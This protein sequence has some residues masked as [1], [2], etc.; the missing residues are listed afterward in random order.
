MCGGD[1]SGRGLTLGTTDAL[2][3]GV[4]LR[5]TRR[6]WPGTS[7][8]AR[9]AGGCDL[10]GAWPARRGLITVLSSCRPPR[11]P[12]ALDAIRRTRMTRSATSSAT[13]NDMPRT[14]RL[15]AGWVSGQVIGGVDT[16]GRTHHAAVVDHLGRRLGDREFP[17]TPAGYRDLMVWMAGHGQLAAVGVEGTGAFGAELARVLASVGVTVMDVDRP[18]RA[19]PSAQREVR[20]TRCLRRRPGRGRRPGHHHPEGTDR[21]GRSGPGAARRARQRDPGPDPGDEP[22][23][24][25]ADRRRP[26]RCGSSTPAWTGSGWSAPWP[27]SDPATSPPALQTR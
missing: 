2:A 24:G 18:D 10:I 17:A 23:Q 3:L 14:D 12:A 8:P 4:V 13:S 19:R 11:V 21:D 26:G 22:D 1:V 15:G 27:G 6:P 20:S 5:L 7:P 25:R 9:V 16:H